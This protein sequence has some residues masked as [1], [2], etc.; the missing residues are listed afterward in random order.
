MITFAEIE[1]SCEASFYNAGSFWHAYTSGKDTP[2]LFADTLDMTYVMNVIARTSLEYPEISILA[3]AVMNNHFHFIL[4]A[5]NSKIVK[6][7]MSIRKRLKRCFP[8]I[9]SASL[10]IKEIDNIVSLRNNIAYTHRNGFVANHAYTPFSYPWSTGRYY[11]LDAPASVPV[12]T[13]KVDELRATFRSRTP[14]IPIDWK[15]TLCGTQYEGQESCESCR[16]FYYISPSSYCAIKLG[17]A[18]FRD[19]HHYYYAVSKN[20]EAYSGIAT[21]LEDT[22]FLT[23]TELFIQIK[24]VLQTQYQGLSLKT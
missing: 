4:C 6:F 10:S 2:L 22:E 15:L 13:L 21:E 5:E 1:R 9:A 16:S 17:M 20:V 7:W 14:Q 12:S 8:D 19:A 3:F 23:D 11:Y 18:M 24:T